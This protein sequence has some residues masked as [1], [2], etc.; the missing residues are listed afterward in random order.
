MLVKGICQHATSCVSLRCAFCAYLHRMVVKCI[1][2]Y[3]LA[4]F[5]LAAVQLRW[6]SAMHVTRK[7]RAALIRQLH[8]CQFNLILC[9]MPFF[10]Y[11]TNTT[12]G[13]THTREEAQT[14]LWRVFPTT[15]GQ[16]DNIYLY[17]QFVY[18][19]KKGGVLVCVCVWVCYHRV[20]H[21]NCW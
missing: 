8:A 11:S 7:R 15:T 18:V 13:L 9:P 3:L 20:K 17:Y 14:V 6:W 19:Q 21:T 5:P 2:F 12:H 16:V 1:S 10:L 4:L